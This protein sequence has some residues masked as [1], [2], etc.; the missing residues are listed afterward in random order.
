MDTRIA[1]SATST[2]VR[3]R[4]VNHIKLSGHNPGERIQTERALQE[5]LG[6]SRSRVR[7]ALASL[8]AQGVI[9]RRIGS[10][11]YLAQNIGRGAAPAALAGLSPDN[12]SPAALMEVRIM[13]EVGMLPLV[14]A[15]ATNN[16]LKALKAILDRADVAKSSVE[17]EAHDTE[18]H[19]RLALS[20]RNDLLS[21][22]SEM[23]IETRK[24]TEWGRAKAK[25]STPRLRR[26]YQTEHRRIVDAI[27]KCNPEQ[28]AAAMKA[29]LVAIRDRLVGF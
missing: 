14:I 2:D 18:F 19:H 6:V 22:F 13:L 7:D 23:V 25:S 12:L 5:L 15:N 24:G 20:A 16:D 17:F 29:H 8:E 27:G 9:T 4:I 10:G 1:P 26:T 11:T 28:A 21:K 3:D